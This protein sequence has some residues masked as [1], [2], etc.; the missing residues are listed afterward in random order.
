M[1]GG[2]QILNN[3]YYTTAIDVWSLG[4]VFAE[5]LSGEALFQGYQSATSQS[6]VRQQ[7]GSSQ[8]AV[9]QQSGSSP[10]NFAVWSLGAAVFAEDGLPAETLPSPQP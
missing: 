10:V 2:E 8:A 7:S 5:M 3:S 4:C 6:A 1:R 9:R